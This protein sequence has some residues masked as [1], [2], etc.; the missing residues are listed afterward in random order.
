[1]RHPFRTPKLGGHDAGWGRSILAVIIALIIPCLIAIAFLFTSSPTLH[2]LPKDGSGYA[3]R[4]HID[5]FTA[6]LAAS[7]IVSWIIAPVAVL[8]LR[9]SAIFGWA[10]W[11]SA[12]LL[13]VIFGLP[14][15]HFA[16]HGDVTTESQAILPHITAAIAFLGLSV[17][18]AF[19]GLV[20]L[21]RRSFVKSPNIASKK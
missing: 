6:C 8:L 17:W 13:A 20:A 18:A 16:L 7:V 10:G 15:V 1:L 4:D 19:W 5:I 14:T 9:A 12:I 2:G 11:G 21:S 3:L